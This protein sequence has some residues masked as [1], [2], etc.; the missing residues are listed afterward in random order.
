MR[1]PCAGKR[2]RVF[3]GFA[4]EMA[5]QELPHQRHSVGIVE[6]RSTMRCA[7]NHLELHRGPN[8]LIRPAEF[9]RLIDGHLR[10]LIAMQQEQ[11]RVV[12]IDVE[13][14]AGEWS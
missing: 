13:N 3:P 12:W 6:H 10:I 5:A 7:R 8:P 1:R 11:G 14:R 9:E 4:S 2:R